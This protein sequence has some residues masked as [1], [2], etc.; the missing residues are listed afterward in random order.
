MTAEDFTTED[1]A[2]MRKQGDM[3]AF[4]RRQY[5][6]TLHPADAPAPDAHPDHIPGAWP[7]GVN[8]AIGPHDPPVLGKV[9]SC[10]RCSVYLATPKP[11]DLDAT[12]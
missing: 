8:A 6:P 2:V 3:R 5:R 12:A 4:I 1:M 10:A 11:Q 7:V 9:C